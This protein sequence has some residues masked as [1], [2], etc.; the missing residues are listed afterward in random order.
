MSGILDVAN[1]VVIGSPVS[2]GQVYIRAP[3]Q[4]YHGCLSHILSLLWLE[5]S[6]RNSGRET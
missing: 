6:N 4:A 2:D 1:H 5:D 3:L